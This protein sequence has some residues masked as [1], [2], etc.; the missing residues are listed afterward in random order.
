MVTLKRARWAEGFFRS[1]ERGVRLKAE[2]MHPKIPE[3]MDQEKLV[4][5]E[6]RA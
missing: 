3:R 6:V 2:K 1:L 4:A 5:V